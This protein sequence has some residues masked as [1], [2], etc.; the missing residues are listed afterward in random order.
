M[1][2]KFKFSLT[3][4]SSELE[5]I[6]ND[7]VCATTFCLKKW[8]NFEMVWL[9]IIWINFD[10][11][12]QKYSKDSKIESACFSFHVRLLVITLSSLKLHTENN[13]CMLC[14]SVSCWARLFLQHLRR[15]SLWIIR[16]TDDRRTSPAHVKFLWL[17]GGSEVCLPDSATATQLCRRFHQYAHCV[18]HCPDAC[19]LFRNQQPVDAVLRPTFVQKLCYKLPSVATFTLIQI[20]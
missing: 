9:E 19:R 16:E 13:A 17:F 14:A 5:D 20:F 1:N 4:V 6:M 8:L 10:D 12:W 11:V 18:C 15:R 7:A 3:Q 2:N